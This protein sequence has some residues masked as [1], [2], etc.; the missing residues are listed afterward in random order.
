M[1]PAND[2][3]RFLLEVCGLTALSYWGFRAADGAMEWIL[4][5]GAPLAMAVVW[6]LFMSP[7]APIRSEDPIRV[8]AEI[9]IFGAAVAGLAG[10]GRPGLALALGLA[11]GMRL[12]M[13][14]RLHQR[15]AGGAEGL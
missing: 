4:G 3:F 7:K 9:A 5:I 11:V 10:A 14:F 8:A 13:T 6:G 15:C 2:G 12:L 1:G